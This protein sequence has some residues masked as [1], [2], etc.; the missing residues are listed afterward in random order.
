MNTGIS[1]DESVGTEYTALRMKRTHRYLILMVNDDK[2]KIEIE[3]VGPREADFAT[4][5]D[6]MPKD[7]CRYV[8]SLTK[9]CLDMDSLSSSTPQV[10]V[11]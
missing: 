11:D 6:Q 7:H 1:C 10:M 4:F 5:K 2:T 8:F 9:L 3:H